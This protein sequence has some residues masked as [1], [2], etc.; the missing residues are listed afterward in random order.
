MSMRG[1]ASDGESFKPGDLLINPARKPKP[2]GFK[3]VSFRSVG[4]KVIEPALVRKYRPRGEN[5]EG[6]R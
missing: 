3:A 4:S 2:G 1:P 5:E 6:T